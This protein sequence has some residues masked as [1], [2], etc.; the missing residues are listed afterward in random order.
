MNDYH[1]P[2]ERVRVNSCA[3]STG[4]SPRTHSL[5]GREH[6]RTGHEI[7]SRWEI[8]TSALRSVRRPAVT[9]NRAGQR[10]VS[11]DTEVRQY[12]GIDFDAQPGLIGDRYLGTVVFDR[13]SR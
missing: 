6:S 9:R 11:L 1:I 3:D 12:A 10:S 8:E 4:S 2:V 5:L 7:V 13:R